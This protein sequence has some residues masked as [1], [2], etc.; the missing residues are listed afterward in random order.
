MAHNVDLDPF[1]QNLDY[2]LYVV[3]VASETET[4]PASRSGC[5]VGFATQCSIDPPRFLVCISKIN[6]SYKLMS[7]ARLVGLHVVDAD[8]R[9]LAVLFGGETGDEIDKFAVCSWQPGLRG[10]PVL[11][12]CRRRLIAEVMA[13][14]DL[15]DH[16]GLV[17]APVE[18]YV[19]EGVAQ[20]QPSQI[21]GMDAGHPL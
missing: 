19:Q 13:R 21:S 18:I 6:H 8:Q 2:P 9:D 10:V 14:V 7:R 11:I 20:L 3:T 5:L 1:M 12:D 17:L 4:G 15:G 16:L